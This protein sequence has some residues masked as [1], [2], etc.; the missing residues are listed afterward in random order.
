MVYRGTNICC[1][2]RTRELIREIKEEEGCHTY[3]EVLNQL[4]DKWE[5]EK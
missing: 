4:I 3:D 5:V 1:E 2:K